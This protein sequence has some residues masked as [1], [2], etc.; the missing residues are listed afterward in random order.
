MTNDEIKEELE[1]NKKMII[2]SEIEY[3]EKNQLKENKTSKF[4]NQ[5]RKYNIWKIFWRWIWESYAI[6]TGTWISTIK[7]MGRI[8]GLKQ[9]IVLEQSK[10]K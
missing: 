8:M 9:I 5:V 10:M 7:K 6:W 2:V 4:K 1:K 3:E